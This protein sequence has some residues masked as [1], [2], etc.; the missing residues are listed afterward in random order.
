MP[1]F[2]V[3]HSLPGLTR[4]VFDELQA[5]A[6]AHPEVRWAHHFVSLTQGTVVSEFEA[7]DLQALEAWLHALSLPYDYILEAEL[8]GTRGSTVDS[9]VP[10]DFSI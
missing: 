8:V 7:P 5:R 4:E 6:D 2:M 1:T 3:S 9:T 10:D